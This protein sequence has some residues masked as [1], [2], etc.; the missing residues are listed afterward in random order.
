MVTPR[1]LP[2]GGGVTPRT[3]SYGATPWTLPYVGQ[4]EGITPMT[5]SYGG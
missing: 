5:L 3:L 1:T 2:Y 4:E